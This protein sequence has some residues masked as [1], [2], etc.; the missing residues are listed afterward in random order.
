MPTIRHPA[1]KFYFSLSELN[2]DFIFLFAKHRLS[3]VAVLFDH[4]M[5][6]NT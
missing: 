5:T 6:T 3:L 2:L 4:G 1:L